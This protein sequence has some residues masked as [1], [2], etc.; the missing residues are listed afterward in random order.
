MKNQLRSKLTIRGGKTVQTKSRGRKA[1]CCWVKWPT[2]GQVEEE[3][4]RRENPLPDAWKLGTRQ[5]P[6]TVDQARA[7]LE[8]GQGKPHILAVLP[9]TRG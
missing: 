1:C 6:W 4:T 7:P 9:Y 8:R 3:K 2:S 5:K